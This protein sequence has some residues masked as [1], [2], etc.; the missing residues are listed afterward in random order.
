MPAHAATHYFARPLSA[1]FPGALAAMGHGPPE[2][3]ID[4]TTVESLPSHFASA[5]AAKQSSAN[6]CSFER[7]HSSPSIHTGP[8]PGRPQTR[9]WAADPLV[10][11]SRDLSVV[12]GLRFN[13]SLRPFGFGAGRRATGRG[14]DDAPVLHRLEQLRNSATRYRARIAVGADVLGVV[15]VLI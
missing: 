4:R 1:I 15:E 2:R 8:T 9:W 5:P 3:T 10:L 14:F 11:C 13:T 12:I 7:L 6:R